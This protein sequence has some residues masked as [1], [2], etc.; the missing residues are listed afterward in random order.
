MKIKMKIGDESMTFD[1]D[2]VE[3]SHIQQA[4]VLVPDVYSTKIRTQEIT[5]DSR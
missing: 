1:V 5:E 4:L 3:I 2:E